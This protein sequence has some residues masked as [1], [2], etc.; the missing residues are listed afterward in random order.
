MPEDGSRLIQFAFSGRAI[1]LAGQDL[2]PGTTERLRIALTKALNLAGNVSLADA[3]SRASEAK[4][5]T[6]AVKAIPDV[7]TA[8]GLRRVAEVPWA[9]V[10]TSSFDD[11]FSNELSLQDS[12][13]RRLRHL[14]VDERLP[15]FFPRRNEVLTVVHLTH[16]A[17]ERST[18]GSP[19][20]GQHWRRAQRLLIPSVLRSLPKAV[21]PAHLLS[22]AGTGANDPID[23]NF[24]L[25]L[26]NELDP[27]NIY[28]FISPSHGLNFSELRELA[29]HI[30]FV[31][32]D[33]SSAIE[34]YSA[35]ASKEASPEAL[36]GK[37][38]EE[39]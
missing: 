26:A 22:I 18:T 5:I 25:D 34:S 6:D 2:D 13:G 10:F 7:G 36:K 38:L 17:D 14:C 15:P 30:H 23:A 3:C 24:V 35:S 28:W 9:A 8:S 11:I 31:E 29:P 16:L 12:Q 39:I 32:S 4:S 19:V 27:D 33:L 37:V 21:G 20:Y 1:L